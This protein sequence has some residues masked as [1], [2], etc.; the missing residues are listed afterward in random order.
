MLPVRDFDITETR[1]AKGKTQAGEI[2]DRRLS[3]REGQLRD[4]ATSSNLRYIPPPQHHLN[5]EEE[6]LYPALAQIRRYGDNPRTNARRATTL[7]CELK[8][9]RAE[10]GPL[11]LL[12]PKFPSADHHSLIWAE[13]RHAVVLR[14]KQVMYNW[15]GMY[16]KH[17]QQFVLAIARDE[18]G[19]T[20]GHGVLHLSALC[21]RFR[22]DLLS[23]PCGAE[24]GTHL[25]ERLHGVI[26]GDSDAD[27]DGIA[28]YMSKYPDARNTLL[29]GH[30]DHLA[31]L[32][33]L[34]ERMIYGKDDTPVKLIWRMP[35][36]W[37]PGDK[38]RT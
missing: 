36:G 10:H 19:H 33:E 31:L 4:E 34:A 29:P 9:M 37:K 16:A 24:G 7:I 23:A 20:H 15:F 18:F 8:S 22:T 17:V 28:C 27:I 5:V 38:P 14:S 12:T 30:S 1:A 2:L 6:I 11:V 13:G 21:Q 26:I 35:K 3:R 32:D 25:M